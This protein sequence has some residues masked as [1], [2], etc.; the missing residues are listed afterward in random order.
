MTT[1]LVD[2]H[3][4]FVTDH[5]V[6]AAKA[7]G[8]VSPDGMP[9]WPSFDIADQLASMDRRGIARAVLS[10]SS[11]GVHFATGQDAEAV[12]LAEHVNDTALGF[13]RDHPD[14]FDFFAS[15]TL[16]DVDAAVR[17]LTRAMDAGAVGITVESNAHGQYLGDFA[18]EPLW[19]E[20][21]RR[22]GI[23][24]IHPTSPVMWES[25]ALGL[26]RPLVEF[27]FE[28]TRT[29]VDMLRA[30]VV[31]RHPGMRVI[32][33][34]SGA[35]LGVLADR[36]STLLPLLVGEDPASLR[37]TEQFEALWFDTAGTPFP[38]AMPTLTSL[39]GTDRILYGS[40]SCWTPPAGVDAQLASIDAAPAPAG[41][42]SWRELAATNAARLL[43]PPS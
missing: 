8:L 26:P 22:R 21:D 34:H 31:D 20:L 33:P 10:V 25:T 37:F 42:S 32:V 40:D 9:G 1:P 23:L 28:S 13:V 43:T 29:V 15:V 7:A 6:A 18:L 38:R 35:T 30:K 11:P 16:P 12:A 19:A 17:E 39:V 27:M 4:H 14:R 5:Y 24:F 41:A 2:V 3:A 36:V